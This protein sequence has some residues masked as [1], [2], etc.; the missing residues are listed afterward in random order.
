MVRLSYLSPTKTTDRKVGSV[1]R[2]ADCYSAFISSENDIMIEI[3]RVLLS[4]ASK[5]WDNTFQ[6]LINHLLIIIKS[7]VVM[8]WI[9]DDIAEYIAGRG[10]EMC[11]FYVP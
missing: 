5:I 11:G 1:G 3:L 2:G 10:T 9:T 6:V 8:S 7:F 4:L